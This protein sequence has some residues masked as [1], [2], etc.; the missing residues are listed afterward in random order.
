MAGG[1]FFE[2]DRFARNLERDAIVLDGE[3]YALMD[4][5]ERLLRAGD[6]LVQRGTNHSWSNRTT[7]TVRI[8]FILIDAI[9]V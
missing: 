7:E 8:A 3:I 4:E 1:D 6:V 5:G 2:E 9:P